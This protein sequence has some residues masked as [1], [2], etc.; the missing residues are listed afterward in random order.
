MARAA[1][2]VTI[3]KTDLNDYKYTKQIY[4][5]CSLESEHSKG[6]LHDRVGTV[7]IY[8]PMLQRY[9]LLDFLCVLK[10]SW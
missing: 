6:I 2:L 8:M 7:G 5:K 9:F 3:R 4:I 10:K 1:L